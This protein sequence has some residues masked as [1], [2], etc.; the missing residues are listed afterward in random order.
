L[1]VRISG[2]WRAHNCRTHRKLQPRIGTEVYF[3]YFCTANTRCSLKIDKI[4]RITRTGGGV[5]EDMIFSH[6]H[7]SRMEEQAAG[8]QEVGAEKEKGPDRWEYQRCIFGRGKPV[9]QD[10]TDCDTQGSSVS[11]ALL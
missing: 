10:D 1:R 6:H 4:D 5:P 9:M 11:V 7:I 8:K 3:A 2:G